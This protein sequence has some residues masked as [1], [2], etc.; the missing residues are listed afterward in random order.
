MAIVCL[1]PCIEF[2]PD[3]A[4]VLIDNLQTL[5]DVFTMEQAGV[6]Y[7]NQLDGVE[8]IAAVDLCADGHCFRKIFKGR[9]F[10]VAAKSDIVQPPQRFSS[11][12]ELSLLKNS[13]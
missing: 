4:I 5:L 7:Q 2:C 6:G 12:A 1:G 9:R 10:A 11:S 13:A 8:S 3:F